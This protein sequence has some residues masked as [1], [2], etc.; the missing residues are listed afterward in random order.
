MNTSQKLRIALI[1]VGLVAAGGAQAL[2]AGG[3]MKVADTTSRGTTM[4]P[5][6]DGDKEQ[7]PAATTDPSVDHAKQ[8]VTDSA[9][10]T[11]IKTK[12]LATKD[13]KSTGIHVKTKDRVVNLT[14]TVP[15][16]E[17]QQMAVDAVKSVEGVDSVRDDLKVSSR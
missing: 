8:A 10:T 7:R 4:A 2:E 15:S 9:L 1:T 12:L 16:K 5:A 17:Q 3:L 6:T 13:L 14:G 11:K